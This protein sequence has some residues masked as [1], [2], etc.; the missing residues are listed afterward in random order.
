MTTAKPTQVLKGSTKQYNTTQETSHSIVHNTSQRER[1]R[2][3]REGGEAKQISVRTFNKTLT[4]LSGK[5]KN[6]HILMYWQSQNSL[7]PSVFWYN[8][9]LEFQI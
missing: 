1:E 5:M 7:A 8:N 4:M 9:L 2:E 3:R 6:I